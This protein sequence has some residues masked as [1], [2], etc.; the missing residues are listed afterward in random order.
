MF[1]FSKILGVVWFLWFSPTS[2]TTQEI[3]LNEALY[4]ALKNNPELQQANQEWKAVKA[5]FWETFAPDH[6]R[7]FM[8]L[9]GI[10]RA[11]RTLNDYHEKKIGIQQGIEFPLYYYLKARQNKIDT[12]ISRAKML[13]IS[14]HISNKVK[15]AFYH[16]L[17]L[18]QQI[19]LHKELLLL[20]DEILQMT[21]LRVFAGDATPY[22]TLKVHVDR[23]TIE[24]S[25]QRLKQDFNIAR[26]ELAAL[27]G[28]PTADEI[29]PRGDIQFSRS[30]FSI[31]TL[32]QIA[33]GIHPE[34]VA[35]DHRLAQRSNQRW[36]AWSD[37]LPSFELSYFQQHYQPDSENRSW[38]TEISLSV[39]LYFLLK[40]QSQIRQANANVHA[41]QF[42]SSAVQNRVWVAIQSALGKLI[43]AEQHVYS[44][45]TR[46]LIEVEELLR[47]ATR[48]YKEGE[49]GYL[50][51]AEALRSMNQIKVGYI[52]ALYQLCAAR[53]D[54]EL[55]VGTSL[56]KT[57][58]K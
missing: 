5:G 49:M 29:I 42:E 20:S 7:L 41:S 48:S 4:T 40:N 50:E 21:R 22:D 43:T 28:K 8:E 56:F 33:L 19:E 35:A 18:Q 36:L 31:D 6:P 23:A 13:H 16:T 15:K 12:H 53:A 57:E 46:S 38:G 27:M 52:E 37:L 2:C 32:F 24:N 47:I 44:L 17:T 10:P 26:T 45:K 55:A 51:V 11:S 34:L 54:L 58:I 1:N 30:H 9:E 14:N 25:Y 39:P 3:S